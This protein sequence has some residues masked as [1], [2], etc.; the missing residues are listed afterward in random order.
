MSKSNENLKKDL[1]GTMNS[2]IHSLSDLF[3][4]MYMVK[5]CTKLV[6]ERLGLKLELDEETLVSFF[7][8]YQL[9]AEQYREF[10]KLDASYDAFEDKIKKT[11]GEF[12]GFC[13]QSSA[14]NENEIIKKLGEI[15]SY[16]SKL[17][18]LDRN[19]CMMGVQFAVQHPNELEDYSLEK[20]IQRFGELQ[21]KISNLLG[22]V[23]GTVDK[24]VG[25]GSYLDYTSGCLNESIQMN[26]GIDE[27]IV[28]LEGNLTPQLQ[29]LGVEVEDFGDYEKIECAIRSQIAKLREINGNAEASKAQMGAKRTALENHKLGEIA[30]EITER[31]KS[32]AKK[33][34]KI[35]ELKRNLEFC[36]T[37]R[38][39]LSQSRDKLKT[40]LQKYN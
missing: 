21:M 15:T 27:E 38:I 33:K 29:C 22:D 13:V 36:G 3:N 10:R 32:I 6:D 26:G 20:E 11:L 24:E 39:K 30:K 34:L 17:V 18:L 28:Q 1:R 5:K 12:R 14:S 19:D 7:K 9:A 4:D 23:S 16:Y 31:E 37:V 40:A 35:E 25:D 8:L 2:H